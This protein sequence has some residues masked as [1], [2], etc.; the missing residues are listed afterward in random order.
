MTH[1]AEK[2]TRQQVVLLSRLV[3]AFPWR[4]EGIFV[5]SRISLAKGNVGNQTVARFS[6][7]LRAGPSNYNIIQVV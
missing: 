5:A 7:F 1:T 3:V 4:K 2:G 6:G